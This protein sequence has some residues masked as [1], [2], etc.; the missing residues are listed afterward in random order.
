MN[1]YC[2]SYPCSLSLSF[3][4]STCSPLSPSL[5]PHCPCHHVHY[6]ITNLLWPQEFQGWPLR[7]S[8]LKPSFHDMSFVYVCVC[9]S[10]CTHS[11]ER[12]HPLG[13]CTPWLPS[14]KSCP[15]DETLCRRTLTIRNVRFTVHV[16]WR[17]FLTGNCLEWNG[18]FQ[19]ALFLIGSPNTELAMSLMCCSATSTLP[20]PY[21]LND[22]DFSEFN[23]NEIAGVMGSWNRVIY[24]F[25][26]EVC[27]FPLSVHYVQS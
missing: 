14:W 9:L 25:T 11:I 18:I 23:F 2:V 15:S 8:R 5:S 6:S 12:R 13:A 7:G 20:H 10:V 3:F 22:M 21:K 26:A 1:S 24:S 19:G 4:F 17:G 16:V 27:F